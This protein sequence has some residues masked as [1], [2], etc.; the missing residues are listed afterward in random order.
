MIKSNKKAPK[1]TIGWYEHI[2]LPEL[3]LSA[4]PAKVDTG[5]RTSALHADKIEAFERDGENWVRFSVRFK[6][7]KVMLNTQC[8]ARLVEKR[9]VS[10]SGGHRQQRY[11]IK[12]LARLGQQEWPI[13]ITLTHRGTMKFPMLL[14]RTALSSR[15][16]VDVSRSNLL[17]KISGS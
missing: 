4:C 12:T 9:V 17:G 14:G 6:S 11:V 5:A 13:E 7:D 10:N 15:F 1:Q 3:G 2:Q 8:E 16:V